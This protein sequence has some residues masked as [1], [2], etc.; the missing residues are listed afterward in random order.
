MTLDP[1]FPILESARDSAF[2][3]FID[4]TAQAMADLGVV[5]NK[6]KMTRLQQLCSLLHKLSVSVPS[7]REPETFT[8]FPNL[9][10]EIRLKIWGITASVARDVILAPNFLVTNRLNYQSLAPAIMHTCKESRQ[11]GKLY[12]ELCTEIYYRRRFDCGMPVNTTWINFSVDRFIIRGYC[13][14][15]PY[16]RLNYEQNMVEKIQHLLVIGF[17]T[18]YIENSMTQVLWLL[19]LPELRELTA[20]SCRE[21]AYSLRVQ[22]GAP[23]RYKEL[24][25]E[26]A[27]SESRLL[28][29]DL[30][31]LELKTNAM[32][33]GVE[34]LKRHGLTTKQ[35]QVEINY[36]DGCHDKH[37]L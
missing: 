16:A 2:S 19:Q 27:T 11:E 26:K 6:G 30:L 20:I 31:L 37:F 23:S 3:K 22:P 10:I 4:E 17:H 7:P 5:D 33:E 35:L 32:R 15:L 8:L 14:L 1:A 9:P 28:T 21:D 34:Y 25:C 24:I 29:R 12:Y 18:K 13:S 36:D